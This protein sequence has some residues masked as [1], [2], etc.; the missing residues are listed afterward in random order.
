MSKHGENIMIYFFCVLVY[1]ELQKTANLIISISSLNLF[2][3]ATCEKIT[4]QKFF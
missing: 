1:N 2:L 4:K 3:E